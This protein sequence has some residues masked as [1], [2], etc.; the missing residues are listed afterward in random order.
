MSLDNNLCK[1]NKSI[2][3]SKNSTRMVKF[4]RVLKNAAV[5]TYIMRMTVKARFKHNDFLNKIL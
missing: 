2:S 3:I 1:A 4:L 5:S